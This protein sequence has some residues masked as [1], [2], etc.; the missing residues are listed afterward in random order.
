MRFHLR[1]TSLNTR[2]SIVAVPVVHCLELTAVDGNDRLAKQIQA[3]TQLNELAAYAANRFAVVLSKVR[4]ERGNI[5]LPDDK[6]T[7]NIMGNVELNDRASLFGEFK[8]VTQ[9]TGT[10][11]RPSSFWD[12]LFGAADN[13]CIPDFLQ[14]VANAA[15]GIAIT[16]DPIFFDARSR[17]ERDTLRFVGG[18]EGEFSNGWNHEFSV[19]YGRYREET[20]RTGQ[21]IVDRFFAAIDAVKDPATGLPACPA[22]VDPNAPAMNT[23]FE[24]PAYQ[25]GYF[26]Y[27]PGSGDCVP[28]NIW[29]GQPGVSPAAAAWVTTPE[30]SDFAIEQFVFAATVTGGTSEYF[31]LPGGAVGFALGGEFRRENAVAKYDTWQRGVIPA[32]SPLPA[33]TLLGEVSDNDSLTFRPQLGIKNEI[34]EYDTRDVFIEVSLPL[35]SGAPFAG[36][37]TVDAAGRWS[38]YSTIGSTVSWKTNLVWTPIG[39]LAFR[40]GVS[41]SV[42]APNVTELFGPEIGTNFRPV[43]SC[44][45]AQIEAL[46]AEDPAL[47]NNF[48]SNCVADLRSFGLDPFDAA[49]NYVFADPLSASFGG[50]T[51]GNRHLREETADTTTYGLIL[52]PE[53]L[54]GFSFTVDYWEIEIEDAIESV[55]SQN[56]VDGCY[57]GASLNTNFCNL[58]TRN[59]NPASAQFGGFNFLRTVD[60]NFAKLKTSGIDLSASYDVSLGAHGFNVTLIGTDVAE[61]DFFTNPGDH[62]DVNPE[63]GEVNRPELAG[64]IYL[65]WDWG[66]LSVGWQS[67]YLDEMLLSF[68]EIE[69]AETLYGDIVIMDETWLHD[70]NV[71]YVVSEGMTLHGG[72]RN[73]TRGKAIRH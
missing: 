66:G 63:L 23:P 70:L 16:V 49:G 64:N 46:S 43:D 39:D 27:T 69:T 53:F 13:P 33:G 73:V 36:E 68:L 47:G 58:F 14:G 6:A 57:Q 67:Q 56:I 45:A 29:A 3:A 9:E 48:L 12:L 60:I 1:D 55:T 11:I 52:R 37:L 59:T 40:G 72:V 5:V 28:L 50:I 61:L 2:S 10:D 19:N 20:N 41:R 54:E 8:Y 31:E 26:S 65:R 18:I 35:L 22:E 42:R 71:S 38:D 32:G 24:I 51:G 62:N 34:G 30:W 44:D 4:N 7:V 15:G 17:T 25:A 21:V